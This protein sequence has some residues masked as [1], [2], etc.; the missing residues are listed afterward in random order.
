MFSGVVL[1]PFVMHGLVVRQEFN[2]V[3][4]MYSAWYILF[5]AGVA[6]QMRAARTA[7]YAAQDALVEQNRDLERARL[8]AEAA[9]LAKGQFLATMSHEI[10][11]PMNG[12]LGMASFL[13][14]TPLDA[15]QTDC[16]ETI[17]RSGEVLLSVINDILD[18][19]KLEAG[20]VVLEPL[21][22]E[23]EEFLRTTRSLVLP[24]A[25]AKNLS[26]ELEADEDLPR[27]MTA[28]PTRL[29]QILL[30]LLGNAIKFTEK[31]RIVLRARRHLETHVRFEVQDSGIGIE[32]SVL[33]ELFRPFEQAD[34]STTRRYGGTGL[35]LAIC[36][37]LA[38]AMK[39]SVGVAS[40][41]GE[42]S[43]FWVELPLVEG[44]ADVGA[45]GIAP[46][47]QPEPCGAGSS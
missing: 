7:A 4:T 34:S 25:Q 19:S 21:R 41:L 18:Y 38:E 23:I 14:E 17:E 31:G 20:K 6:R 12:V 47:P 29:R 30:N 10:R 22:F 2:L 32:E 42:G 28:D 1:V 40:A 27:E 11:T 43:R 24:N 13:R 35:G 37:Q 3:I 44:S 16:V 45:T 46:T 36:R 15:E 8:E 9:T 26:V 33:P 39:G 5:L